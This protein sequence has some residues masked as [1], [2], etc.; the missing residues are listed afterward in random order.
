MNSPDLDRNFVPDGMVPGL[1]PPMRSREQSLGQLPPL[2]LAATPGAGAPFGDDGRDIF[3]PR[4]QHQGSW[5][6]L[7]N[8]QALSSNYNGNGQGQHHGP[9]RM[10]T[11]PPSSQ[12]LNALRQSPNHLLQQQQLLRNPRNNLDLSAFAGPPFG[13][14][15]GGMNVGGNMNAQQYGGAIGGNSGMGSSSRLQDPMPGQNYN[16]NGIGGY[17]FPPPRETQN[18]MLM[19]NLSMNGPSMRD[20]DVGRS[21][22]PGMAMYQSQSLQQQQHLLQQLQPPPNN[23]GMPYGMQLPPIQQL[24]QS[25]A[26][27]MHGS[28]RPL[29]PPGVPNDYQS[30]GARQF[31]GPGSGIGPSQQGQPDL[32]ALLM[33]RP[34]SYRGE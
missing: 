23:Q 28:I 30:Y 18:R 15:N 3:A 2:N 4:L 17:N 22:G 29:N 13:G 21:N 19:G 8:R 1:R 10:S 31:S 9:P 20:L 6:Q 16:G 12:Q 5:E 7:Q 33:G 32:M 24:N 26:P 11:L 27:Q 14:Q 25:N 34:P